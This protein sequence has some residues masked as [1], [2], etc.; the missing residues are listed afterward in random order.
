MARTL[1]DIDVNA[2]SRFRALSADVSHITVVA[3]L[4]RKKPL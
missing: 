2:E 3:F 4:V 1:P